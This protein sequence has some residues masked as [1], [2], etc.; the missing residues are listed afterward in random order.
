LPEDDVFGPGNVLSF[1]DNMVVDDTEIF[2]W[3]PGW[4]FTLAE[5]SYEGHDSL[6]G[7][8]IANSAKA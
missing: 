7:T 4:E 2:Q 6:D 3:A 1:L 8:G 5:L